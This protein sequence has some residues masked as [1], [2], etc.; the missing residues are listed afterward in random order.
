MSK[1][2]IFHM[3][4]ICFHTF[5]PG[6]QPKMAVSAGPACCILGP[7]PG[8]RGNRYELHLNKC[9]LAVLYDFKVFHIHIISISCS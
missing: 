8:S 4:F 5:G 2:Y 1:S 3:Y 7:R 9:D 6:A